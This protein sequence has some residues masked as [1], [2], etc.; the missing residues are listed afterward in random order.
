MPNVIIATTMWGE[1]KE[2]NGKLREKELKRDFWHDMVADGCRIER[3]KYT[4][5]SAWYIVDRL[6]NAGRVKVQLSHEMVERGLQLYQTKAGF[7]LSNELKKLLK[8]RKEASRKLRE[9]AKKQDNA[10][11]TQELSQR[12]LE[13][14]RKIIQT[15]NE[16]QKL[17]TPFTAQI[18]AWFSSKGSN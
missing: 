1:V 13:I 5:Y 2:T 3:F 6:A 7:T 11:V 10:L 14:D 17:K 12:Q 15:A 18:R 16:L 9:Q 4:Y 8:A